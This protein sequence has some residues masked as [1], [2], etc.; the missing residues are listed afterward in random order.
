LAFWIYKKEIGSD[1]R[2]CNES[3]RMECESCGQIVG[4]Y[5]DFFLDGKYIELKGD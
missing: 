3:D 5:P 4:Y 2:K 1:I